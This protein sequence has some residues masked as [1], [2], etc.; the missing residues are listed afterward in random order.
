MH[1]AMVVNRGVVFDPLPNVLANNLLRVGRWLWMKRMT[2]YLTP[3]KSKF[4]LSMHMRESLPR[5]IC[6]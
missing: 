4:I 5:L 2:G 1:W 3:C 6:G